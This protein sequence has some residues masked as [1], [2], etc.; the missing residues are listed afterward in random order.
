[1]SDQDFKNLFEKIKNHYLRCKELRLILKS[2]R[3]KFWGNNLKEIG[4]WT[5]FNKDLNYYNAIVCIINTVF[6]KTI[7]VFTSV[8]GGSNIRPFLFYKEDP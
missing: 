5:Q 7:G 6:D 8:K 1:M 4:V 3:K 2:D